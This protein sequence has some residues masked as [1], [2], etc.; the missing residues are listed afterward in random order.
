VSDEVA[1]DRLAPHYR[2]YASARAA[3]LD[4]V[5]RFVIAHAPRDGQMLDVGAGDGVRAMAIARALSASK[6]VLCEP[7]ER[8]A[9]LCREQSAAAVWTD[10]AQCL[11]RHAERFDVITCLWN[12]LGHL[13]DCAARTAALA[14][15]RS[16]LAPDGRIFCD[17]NNRHNARAY[18][19]GIVMLRRMLDK[20]A[21]DERRGDATFEWR[22]GDERIPARGHLFTPAEMDGIVQAAG[23]EVEQRLTVDYVSG[24]TSSCPRSGQLV[25]RLRAQPFH[26]ENAGQ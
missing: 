20:L 8:M 15:M 13:P 4:A 19:S 1:Y 26:E 7:S 9:A 14:G 5:D 16:L 24:Q 25:Y 21:P 17:V 22:V 6:V 10:P 2:A 12:V 23:L 3:Y 11:W 18:G